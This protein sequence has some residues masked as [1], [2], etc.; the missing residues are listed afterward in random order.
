MTAISEETG[1][2][3]DRM[4]VQS[5]SVN[6]A[7]KSHSPPSSVPSIPFSSFDFRIGRQRNGQYDISCHNLAPLVTKVI[8]IELFSE[9]G[10]NSQK[11]IP[12]EALGRYSPSPH[13]YPQDSAKVYIKPS[14]PYPSTPG[15]EIH[16]VQQRRNCAAARM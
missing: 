15:F 14:K 13:P 10:L 12:P 1:D 2:G 11:P 16:T 9:L 4:G 7:R 8:E 6:S 5:R 3:I